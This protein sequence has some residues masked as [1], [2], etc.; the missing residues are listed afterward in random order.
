MLEP[1]EIIGVDISQGMLD[2]AIL[3]AKNRQVSNVKFLRGDSENLQFDDN[4]FDAATV[5]FG[6]R[7][8]ENLEKGLSEILR[9]LKPGAKLAVL[10]FSK[11]KN[12]PVKQIYNFYFNNILPTTGRMISKD[13]RAYTYLPESVKAFPEGSDF[14]KIL[15]KV[16]FENC[17][18]RPL[19]FG[20]CS[21]YTAEKK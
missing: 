4:T 3:K 20:I 16:G 15:D 14:V 21:L 18:D 10:E 2:K 5:A 1:D 17:V 6:V 13:S 11:P 19:L 9:V 8:F 7:N 12:V